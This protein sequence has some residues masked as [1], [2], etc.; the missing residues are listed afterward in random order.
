MYAMHIV[1]SL[2]FHTMLFPHNGKIITID[3]ITNQEPN[4]LG[5]ID[6]ILPLVHSS[7]DL[8]PI[9]DVKL[10]LFQYLSLMGTYQVFPNLNPTTTIVFIIMTNGEEMPNPPSTDISSNSTLN[11]S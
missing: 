1:S 5:H 11:P 2:G 4:Q 10:G 6:N 8:V 3:Q 7:T 9:I